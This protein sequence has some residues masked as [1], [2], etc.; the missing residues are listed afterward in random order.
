MGKKFSRDLS[1]RVLASGVMLIILMVFMVVYFFMIRQ[2]HA[3]GSAAVQNG[4]ATITADEVTAR[5]V[6]LNGAWETFDGVACQTPQ[7]VLDLGNTEKLTDLPVASITQA[8][9]TATYRMTLN[10]PDSF[11]QVL[12]LTVP[13]YQG[14]LR[15]FVNGVPQPIT[16]TQQQWISS[17]SLKTVFALTALESGAGPQQIVIS[18]DFAGDPITLYRRNILIGTMQNNAAL[19][20][21]E[22]SGEMLIL[23]MLLLMLVNG[24]VF[25][26]FRPNHLLITMIT[27]FDT[28]L[29]IRIFFSL[30]YTLSLY[31][32]VL[33]DLVIPDWFRVSAEL[34]F[35]MIAGLVGCVL[36][37]KLFD[38][39][40]KAPRWL[41]LP[42]VISYIAF[43]VI[44]PLNVSFFEA[45]GSKILLFV[46]AYTFIGVFAE[47]VICW[48]ET[49]RRGYF[50]F[51]FIK[52][53]YIG[54][55]VLL[56]ICF[57]TRFI[58]FS[59]L[60]YL[61]SIFFMMHVIVRL[62]DNNQSYQSV[63]VLN[64][65]LEKTVAE[66]TQELSQ[67]N[68]ILSELSIRDPLTNAFNRLYFEEIMEKMLFEPKSL[69]LCIFDL[70][71]FK[72]INDTYGHPA[73][74]EMLRRLTTI[75]N[76][77]VQENA[78]FARI[79]GEEFVLLYENQ[80]LQQVVDSISAVHDAVAENAKLSPQYTTAS[81]GVAMWETGDTEKDLLSKADSA[82]YEAKNTGRNRV[83]L[84][85]QLQ[86]LLEEQTAG[87]ANQQ[88]Q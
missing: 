44:F 52:T 29:M 85:A 4:V 46:Y 37:K 88:T 69:F 20:I 23:G 58:E 61:Y 36:A 67:A 43:A 30:N 57:W 3:V 31:R 11:G 32:A 59:V 33:P 34:F 21:F 72:R 24:Y 13:N 78:V 68:K 28:M 76:Q 80:S 66:R 45:Y 17:H 6:H 79:G 53:A 26:L 48:R 14:S 54:C 40:G 60:L 39:E 74:D 86:K 1:L 71:F 10:M 73:G 2:L 15:V 75:V 19:T 83:V 65:D 8:Q 12:Y 81:F 63:E 5:P 62:Y 7:D 51:Q 55:V 70:D 9:R 25:M 49:N 38:P 87:S 64:R 18:G 35:L 56:D 50:L 41:T 47:F 16:Q 42:P 77:A 27:V 84:H 82:L 22:S